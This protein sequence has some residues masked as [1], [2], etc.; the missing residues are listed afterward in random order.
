LHQTEDLAAEVDAVRSAAAS[1]DGWDRWANVD[2]VLAGKIVNIAR[3]VAVT[4]EGSYWT[5]F[6]AAS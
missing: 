2:S 3:T 4:R 1:D 6:E 5:Y